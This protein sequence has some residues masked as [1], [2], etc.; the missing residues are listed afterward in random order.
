MRKRGPSG[1]HWLVAKVLCPRVATSMTFDFTLPLGGSSLSEGRGDRWLPGF[2][3]RSVWPTGK[4]RQTSRALPGR[5]RVRPSRWEG[6]LRWNRSL[7]GGRVKGRANEPWH[8]A[9]FVL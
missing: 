4:R 9:V 6:K 2:G 8:F 5:Y 1:Q 3:M 7:P